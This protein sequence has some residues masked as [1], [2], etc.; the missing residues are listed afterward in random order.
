MAAPARMGG[1]GHLM[2]PHP[3][4]DT[5]LGLDSTDDKKPTKKVMPERCKDRPSGLSNTKD[6]SLHFS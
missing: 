3:P 1:G 5:P 2:P 4:S 6:P